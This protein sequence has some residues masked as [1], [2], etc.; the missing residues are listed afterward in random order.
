MSFSL[1]AREHFKANPDRA[2]AWERAFLELQVVLAYCDGELAPAERMTL[3]LLSFAKRDEQEN[4]EL[5]D[6]LIHSIDRDGLH[7]AADQIVDSIKHLLDEV[8]VAQRENLAEEILRESIAIVVADDVVSDKEREFVTKRLGPGLGL[9]T[10]PAE[11]LLVT[12]SGR[13]Q[14]ARTYA[15]RGFELYLMLAD[16]DADAPELHAQEGEPLPPFL[17]AVDELVGG[18]WLGSSRVTAYFLSALGGM[19]WVDQHQKHVAMLGQLT[20][21]VRGLRNRAGLEERLKAIH[22]ELTELRERAIDPHAASKV[23]RHVTNAISKMRV[24]TD[25]QRARFRDQI[26]P[27]VD[28]D[29]AA[30]LLT[31]SRRGSMAN[32]HRNLTGL[33][34]PQDGAAAARRWWRFWK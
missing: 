20:D 28:I 12:A 21:V 24:L 6:S 16:L 26:A 32:L 8:S 7:R 18:K 3:S 19:F 11:Q 15:E 29:H 30:L 31:A 10:A 27:A 2:D 1:L 14:R 13:L 9:G 17:T 34:V 22:D 25:D 23:A 4:R 5:V 33:R